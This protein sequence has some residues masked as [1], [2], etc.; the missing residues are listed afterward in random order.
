MVAWI[1]ICQWKWRQRFRVLVFGCVDA[2]SV[3]LGFELSRPSGDDLGAACDA[4]DADVD[5]LP[6]IALKAITADKRSELRDALSDFFGGDSALYWALHSAIWPR[7]ADYYP[8]P[9]REA[10][11]LEIGSA[12]FDNMANHDAPWRYVTE[13]WCDDADD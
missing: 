9:M 3:Y 4:A 7:Y 13:G 12:D 5:D 10:L 6:I 1:R 11:E 8:K 2:L